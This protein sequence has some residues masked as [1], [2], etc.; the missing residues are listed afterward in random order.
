LGDCG[1]YGEKDLNFRISETRKTATTL[2]LFEGF[3]NQ[4]PILGV[5]PVFRSPLVAMTKLPI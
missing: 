4:R 5:R 1:D 3:V 2:A